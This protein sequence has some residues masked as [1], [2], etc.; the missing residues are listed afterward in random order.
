MTLHEE[1]CSVAPLPTYVM[2]VGS[3]MVVVLVLTSL[4][5]RFMPCVTDRGVLVCFVFRQSYAH[6]KFTKHIK[7]KV[8]CPLLYDFDSRFK[9]NTLV[10]QDSPD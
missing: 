10:L 5:P 1:T 2:M 8:I 4:Y 9:D 7:I 3:E 6:T